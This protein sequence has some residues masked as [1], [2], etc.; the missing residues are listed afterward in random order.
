MD[1][2]RRLRSY[3][4]LLRSGRAIRLLSGLVV[5]AITTTAGFSIWHERLSVF[6]QHEREMNSM[7]I[8]LAEQTSRYVQVVDIVVQAVQSRIVSLNVASPAD[9]Q[10]D[11]GTPEVYGYL[12]ECLRNVPQIDAVVLVDANGLVTNWSRG[13]P[14]AR[15]DS[16]D[17]DFY[18]Y[19]R[20]HDDPGL[21]IG[22]LA[23]NRG[24]GK[25]SLFFARRISGPD[26]TFLGLVLGVL[27]IQYLS[28]FYRAAGERTGE[29][30]TLL[31]RDGTMLMRYPD[32]AAAIGI[33]LPQGSP[34][35]ARV[36]EG[37]GSYI[38]PGVLDGKPSLVSVHPVDDYGLVVD[39]MMEEAA[40]F[41]RWRRHAVYI[42]SFALMAA[43]AFSGLFLM[44]ARQFQRQ[45][46]QNIEL[47][48]AA[49]RLSE[50][51][52]I[53][54]AYT[55]MSVDW[56]W[57]QDGEHRYKF[58]SGIRFMTASDDTGKTRWD[59]ADPGMDNDRWI[60]H[61]TD[62]AARRPFRNF[63][64][65]RIGS[66]GQRHFISSNGDPV[67][68][69]N[70]VFTGYRGTGRD[71]SAEV[72]ATARLLRLNS[73]LELGR[74]QF[75]A[76]LNSMSQGVCLFDGEKRLVLCNRRYAAIYNLPPEA[77]R[78]GRSLEQIVADRYAS[79]S[80]L[81]MSESDFL[82]WR[83]QVVAAEQPSIAVTPLKNGRIVAIHHQPMPGGGWVAIHEDIT[84]R[85]QAEASI[86][87]MAH[88]DALTKLPNR[89]L[90]RERVEQAIAMAGRGTQFAVICLD[91]DNFKQINDTLGHPIG[92]GLLL[93][94]ADRL[95]S[96]VRDADTVARLGGDE[97]AIIQI[98][99]R[100]PEDAEALASRLIAAFRQPFDVA[101]HQI[102]SGASIGV[103]VVSGDS[104]SFETLMRDADIALY[105][106]KTEGRGTVRFFEPEMDARIHMRRVLE[107]E[108]QG[109]IA[110]NEFELY[111]Q[112]QIDLTSNKVSGFEALLRWHHPV[113]GLVSPLDFIPV[114][115]ETGMIGAI[116]EWVLRTACFEAENWPAGISVAV[117]LSPVQFKKGDL[118][119]AVQAA[120][121]AS[122]L[123][124]D[125][126]ELEITESV[127]LRD[128]AD[129][130]RA[131]HQLR[132]M[133][134]CIALDDF[135]TGYSSLSYLRS[136]PFAK[137]KIDKSFVRDLMTNNGSMSIIRA[138]TGLGQS[139]GMRTIAEGVETKEQLERL[140]EEGCDE[141]QGFLFSR[142][143]P[144]GEVPS[145]IE[146]LQEIGEVTNSMGI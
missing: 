58:D 125:R 93:A 123:R 71:I 94:V 63:L 54:R 64:W 61:Q 20:E 111:Y 139:L 105:L 122:G 76:V 52:Q 114:A 6:E 72:E 13:W 17:R 51:Q 56:L 116:G 96:C 132:S 133:G 32:P 81:D 80:A 101:D 68:D 38:S 62:L 14:V 117:N 121:A 78:P 137:I 44:L 45:V 69:R 39:V 49:I 84:E 46:A 106:A 18:L 100:Q 37:G 120:L 2:I 138:V 34:W 99:V 74:L 143:R 124:P 112:P 21:F 79:G 48:E 144:A 53:L 85:Q 92:D 33:K 110:R 3:V 91:L 43:V 57:E 82:T 118:V 7:G 130:L 126:L 15:V 9:T 145:L 90:F 40:V 136:F 11:W 50:G 70:G 83:D 146:R 27:D 108:L 47:E 59:I 129:T 4:G 24:T 135:G 25:L 128:T 119:A 104:I 97:F 26:G 31:R 65:E 109:A 87:F 67:F 12:A 8:V 134:I 113:R 16:S 42:A 19:F 28:D 141:V 23:R 1:A 103:T 66:D 88:H 89:M 77:T 107:L 127:F 5:A 131:L 55:D 36:A 95:Q 142:P 35:Y 75:D 41:A 86:V 73:D 29:A 10:R 98:G 30:V 115:E 22:S 60:R 140:R 102:M